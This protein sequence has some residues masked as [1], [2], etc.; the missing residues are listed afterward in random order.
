MNKDIY[1]ASDKDIFDALASKKI[2][3]TKSILT[4]ICNNRGIFVSRDEERQ[5]LIDYISM[6]PHSVQD[7][8]YIR[9]NVRVNTKTEKKTSQKLVGSSLKEINIDEAIDQ[10]RDERETNFNEHYQII[11]STPDKIII[12]VDFEDIDFGNTRLKQKQERTARIEIEKND[13]TISIRHSANERIDDITEQ[14]KKEIKD[15]IPSKDEVEE[16][17][18][19]LSEIKVASLR[20]LFFTELIK[21]MNNL[22]FEEV[23]SINVTSFEND[24]N[25]EVEKEEVDELKQG[26]LG[27]LQSAM[28]KGENLL[29]T[30]EYENF[31]N[32]GFY[33][34]GIKWKSKRKNGDR[35][36]FEADFQDSKQCKDFEYDV[37]GFY[38]WK[39]EAY[40]KSLKPLEGKEK[41]DLLE[42]IEQTSLQAYEKI[43]ENLTVKDGNK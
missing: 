24:E 30:P 10:L 4:E 42:N 37:K 1:Y 19:D 18:I 32:R 41:D 8:Q 6:L 33:I 21:K 38:Q 17:T 27:K 36:V 25:N 13:E 22:N 12:D 11:S 28:L 2:F 35:I 26:I 3:F 14:L 23:N 5:T 29:E 7:L 9:D 34:Y 16:K 39:N 20:T 40:L 15:L 31:T 43:K